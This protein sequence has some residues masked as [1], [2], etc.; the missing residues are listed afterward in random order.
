[1]HSMNTEYPKLPPNTVKFFNHYFES[2]HPAKIISW[3][4]A[5]EYHKWR[6]LVVFADGTET[7]AW[8]DLSS[9]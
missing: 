7:Y 6:A 1:M 4:F 5:R 9:I 8:P 2:E 3:E